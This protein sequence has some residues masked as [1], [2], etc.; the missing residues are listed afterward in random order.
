MYD[1]GREKGLKHQINFWHLMY[2][3]GREKRL[4]KAGEV[5]DYI[6]CINDKVLVEAESVLPCCAV[7]VL[8][9]APIQHVLKVAP[10]CAL[11]LFQA[12]TVARAAGLGGFTAGDGCT[13]QMVVLS[14]RC[15]QPFLTPTT[16]NTAQV[17]HREGGGWPTGVG[18]GKQTGGP[19]STEGIITCSNAS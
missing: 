17:R 2:D 7:V 5:Q 1:C 14:G 10:S 13:D 18:G 15:S 12:V 3:C 19:K 6:V 16:F 4:K 11:M 9:A 8:I